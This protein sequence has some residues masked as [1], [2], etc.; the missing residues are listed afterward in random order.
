MTIHLLGSAKA[1]GREPAGYLAS[2]VPVQP[3]MLA[4]EKGKRGKGEKGKK[5]CH[6]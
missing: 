3:L 6:R 2:M 4:P 1:I 5:L